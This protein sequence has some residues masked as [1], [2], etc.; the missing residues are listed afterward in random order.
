MSDAVQN[1]LTSFAQ[2]S[3]PEQAVVAKA[4]YK[5]LQPEQLEPVLDW[6]FPDDD[7][8]A[9]LADQLFQTYD[10]EDEQNAQS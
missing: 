5:K 8:L 6:S 9:F 2:L 1:L 4:I 7:E 10:R 3:R